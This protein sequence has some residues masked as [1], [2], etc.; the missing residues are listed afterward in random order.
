MANPYIITQQAEDIPKEYQNDFK[1]KCKETGISDTIINDNLQHRT[2]ST[3][4]AASIEYNLASKYTSEFFQIIEGLTS[5]QNEVKKI[6]PL[7]QIAKTTSEAQSLLDKFKTP[8][9]IEGKN[10]ELTLK[11]DKHAL[12]LAQIQNNCKDEDE[13]SMIDVLM[14]SLIMQLGSRGTYNSLLDMRKSNEECDDNGG[15]IASEVSYINNIL[16]NRH[17]NVKTYQCIQGSFLKGY[18]ADFATIRKDLLK[19]LES[20]ENIIIGQLYF[21]TDGKIDGAHEISIIGHYKSTDGKHYFVCQ[22]SDDGV[23]RPVLISE[24]KLLPQIHHALLET[25]DF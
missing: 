18:E 23:T 12:F 9:K 10:V 6:I 25:K 17:K 8:Y 15:L 2:T 21:N 20:N 11:P 22:D 5:E 4:A 1:K 24:E 13:R 7:S 19:A 14:Q 16:A 3:C